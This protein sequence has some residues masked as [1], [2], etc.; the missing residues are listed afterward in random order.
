MS[1]TEEGV[2]ILQRISRYYC[3]SS[4]TPQSAIDTFCPIGEKRIDG[5]KTVLPETRSCIGASLWCILCAT[6]VRKPS[7]SVR[8][9]NTPTVVVQTPI[10][11]WTAERTSLSRQREDTTRV[12]RRRRS[13]KANCIMRIRQRL[14]ELHD[15]VEE[16]KPSVGMD[17]TARRGGVEQQRPVSQVSV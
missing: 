15:G 5:I 8:W 16:G 13:I 3:I 12:L 1:T 4:S 17:E 7:E 6:N 9:M 10:L 11:V 2:H 14:S